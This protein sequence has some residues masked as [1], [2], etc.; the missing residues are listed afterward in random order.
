MAQRRVR[1]RVDHERA[2][3]AHLDAVFDSIRAELG[4]PQA[5]PDDVLD[6]ARTAAADPDVPT[7]DLTDVA[8]FT[9]D[10]AGSTDLDQ[11]MALDREGAG[12][13]V[14]YAIADVPAF[15]APGGPIDLEARRRG[16]TLYA[17]DRRTPLHP[18]V[19]SEDAASLLPGQV[20]PAF[21]W[22]L[23]LDGDGELRGADVRRAMVRSVDRLDYDSLQ[24]ELDAGR[25][26]ERIALL[27]EVGER[28]IAL[29]SARGGASLPMP[30]Q[31]VEL[32]DGHYVLRWRP[33]SQVEDWNAQI[34]LLTGMA[35]A[36]MMLAGQV[37]ILR[38]MPDPDHRAVARFRRQA[39]ALGA[40]WPAEQAY[41][42]FLRGLDRSNPHHLA[43]IHEATALFR[44][45]GYTPFD[46]AVP[47]TTGH[48]AV[49]DQ[50]A[51]VTAPLRRLVDRF[52][53]VVCEA[54]CRDADVPGW[55]REALP[56][57]ASAMATSDQ[58]AG[59]LER[60][61]TDAVEA[62]VLAHRVGDTFE[63]VVVDVD[64]RADAAKVGEVPDSSTGGVVQLTEP[65]VLA[66][67][68]G[69]VQLGATLRVRLAAAD[70]DQRRVEFTPA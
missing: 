27:R 67:V 34:S 19:I 37:G 31:E 58:Q 61:C 48:A 55:V 42:D 30:E 65:P 64:G 60:A 14:R 69:D 29:E 35:A 36:D 3:A 25:V 9:I 40:R 50:Y 12:F 41:G 59:R 1:L 10:P 23:R 28:R 5:F 62:A 57:L 54:L 21:V 46:G 17:P 8:F 32:D 38:T 20:R 13:R 49:A 22:D 18:P 11:A 66:P 51:H 7:G 68:T 39:V 56:T 24:A 26:D 47:E 63:A 2:A 53:L 70:V 4:V 15:V 45:A 43:L 44:G 33:P 6:A 52:G 16:Q